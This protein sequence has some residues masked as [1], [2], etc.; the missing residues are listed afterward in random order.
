MLNSIGNYMSHVDCD[1]EMPLSQ[2]YL[3]SRKVLAMSFIDGDRCDTMFAA[4]APRVRQPVA[5][6]VRGARRDAAGE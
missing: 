1:I 3:C 2:P 5:R 4:A 6:R